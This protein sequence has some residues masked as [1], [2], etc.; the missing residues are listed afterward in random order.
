MNPETTPDPEQVLLGAHP[1]GYLLLAGPAT[2]PGSPPPLR[3]PADTDGWRVEERLLP[4]ATLH[5]QPRTVLASAT[6]R[7][8]VL[9]LL[10]HPVDVA[11][12][13][14]DPQ[15]I[16]GRLC[17]TWDHAGESA[18]VDEAAALGGRWTLVAGTETG[19][20]T[21]GGGDTGSRLL[22]VPDTHASQPVFLGEDGGR[23]ALAS[24]A[25]LVADALGAGPD[26]ESVALLETM[27]TRLAGR[28]A[29]MPGHRTAYR[30]VR[31][32]LP[33]LLARLTLDRGRATATIEQERFWPR[34]PRV[35]TE[36]V[37]A[38]YAAFGERITAHVELLSRLGRPAV[39]LTAGMDSRV[40]AAV[41]GDL[42]RERDGLTFTYLNPRDAARGAGAAEDVIGASAVASALGVPHRVLRWRQPP[43]GGTFDVLHRRTYAPLVP[44]R[45]AA[46]AMWADLPRDLVQLQSNG[47]E[48]G[49]TFARARRVEP[50]GPR[51]L[52]EMMMGGPRGAHDDLA[53]AAYGDYL[54]SASF[55]PERLHGYD[56]HDVFYWE[57][58]MGRWGWQKFVDG[59][60]GHRILLPFNDRVLLETMLSLPYP[61]RR[62]RVL[63]T[64]LFEDVPQVR[65]GARTEPLRPRVQRAVLRRLPGTVRGKV[66][67]SLSERHRQAALQRLT[68]PGGYALLPGTD[69]R[70]QAGPAG[71]PRQTLPGTGDAAARTTLLRHPALP[72]ALVGDGDRDGGEW[73]LVL[74]EPVDVDAGTDG[75]WAV[76]APL[77]DLL[78]EDGVDAAAARACA[79]AGSWVVVLGTAAGTVLLSDPLVS[80]GARRSA[81]GR[82]V[83]SHESLARRWGRSGTVQLGPEQLLRGRPDASG[84]VSWQCEEA[85]AALDGLTRYAAGLGI[86]RA[87]R[88]ARHVELL[89]SRGPAT[90]ALAGGD[91]LV[92]LAGDLPGAR[93]ITWWDRTDVGATGR[94]VAASTEAAAA[95]LAHRVVP[96]R[97][98]TT[99]EHRGP[100]A[101]GHGLQALMR[102]W[103]QEQDRSTPELPPPLGDTLDDALPARAVLW[104]GTAPAPGPAPLP[105]T[106]D[107][108]QG[109]RHTALPFSD[110][111][112]DLLD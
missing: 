37:D 43:E 60:F 71:W 33:N 4:G 99:T 72:H 23:V 16:A 91:G 67:R 32:L 75:A 105:R 68:W 13:L 86:T 38:V 30:G 14:V 104:L 65:L 87:Q 61:A 93:A 69:V 48:S 78:R 107:L 108:V 46:H 96:L 66:D 11:A 109:V 80:L 100:S 29:F 6:G 95:G 106:L 54:D 76:A 24:S 98:G 57:Q 51:R 79:L 26:E 58:R 28:T 7:A 41:A 2:A 18:L 111:V 82:A 44:S 63:F 45:G 10:G 62:D 21:G 31:A 94:M 40:T 85:T 81:D 17:T 5:L 102:T 64:R 34:E 1:H 84:Q 15:V 22:V 42:L 56:H 25:S 35:G 36:D 103:E 83:L 88:L 110:R 52:T 47:A 20:G 89:S 101:P 77:L 49:T 112:L 39:S 27:R 70:R 8:G 59:D 9:V 12:G 53:D 92:E 50:L 73:V 74:G 3:A 90:L 97:E 19:S 55:T